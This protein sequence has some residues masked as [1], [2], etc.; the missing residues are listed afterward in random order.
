MRTMLLRILGLAVAISLSAC[1][2]FYQRQFAVT[3]D[4][5]LSSEERNTIAQQYETFMVANGYSPESRSDA[6]GRVVYFRV[7][8]AR[9]RV[10]PT[11]R[12]TDVLSMRVD[13]E[14]NLIIGLHRVSSY[15]PDNF[16]AQ[17]VDAFVKITTKHLQETTGKALVLQEVIAK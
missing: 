6:R 7:S 11:S 5:P 16:T 17:Y 4:R 2:A 3:M 12:V 14:G 10:L 8:D 1:T 9:S 13:P 15:P